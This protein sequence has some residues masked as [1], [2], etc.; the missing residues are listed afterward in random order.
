MDLV[1]KF[2]L[3]FCGSPLVKLGLV[4]FVSNDSERLFEIGGR[5]L[6]IGSFETD[7][8]DGDFTRRRNGEFDDFVHWDWFGG[9]KRRQ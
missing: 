7:G 8:V 6:A 5:A 9:F 4:G 1:S 2:L 3:V